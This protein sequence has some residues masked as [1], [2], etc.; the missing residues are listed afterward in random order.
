MHLCHAP[1]ALS[2][3]PRPGEYVQLRSRMRARV[4]MASPTARHAVPAVQIPYG[5]SPVVAVD[6]ARL[7]ELQPA[8]SKF[9][10]AAAKGWKAFVADP[11][12]AAREVSAKHPPSLPC[13]QTALGCRT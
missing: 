7:P 9:M 11:A 8:L 12:A 5:Y 10:A 3:R 6:E 4:S 13:M 1:V 2:H